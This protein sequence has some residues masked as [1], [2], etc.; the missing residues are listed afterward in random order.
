M[1]V[2]LPL[3]EE[4]QWAVPQPCLAEILTLQP[5]SGEPPV[6]VAWRGLDIPVLDPGSES[7][8]PW[9]DSC[10]GA[11]LVA[12]MLGMSGQGC[13]YW[14]VALRGNGL[15]A[16]RLSAEECEDQPDAVAENAL[17]AFSL[18]GNVYQVPDL[19]AMQRQAAAINVTAASPEGISIGS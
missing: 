16:H 3:G 6:S 12:V 19:P 17:A 4:L 7:A 5:E 8:E 11:G 15:A 14:A 10:T 13:D 2:L 18:K 1:C 9:L